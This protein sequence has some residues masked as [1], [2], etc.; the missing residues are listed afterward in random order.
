MATNTKRKEKLL[1]LTKIFAIIKK[2]FF[3]L[4]RD[5]I[6]IIPL[7]LMPVFMILILGFVTGNTPK[8]I[9]TAIVSY[10]NSPISQNIIQAI[11]GNQYF[12]VGKLVGE[13]GQ[14][15]QLLD[16]GEVEVIVEIPPNFGEDIANSVQT[17]IIVI[18]DESD[19]SIAMTARQQLQMIVQGIASQLARNKLEAYQQSVSS[20]AN[21][22]NTYVS[23]SQNV[24]T[25]INPKLQE[26]QAQLMASQNIL[27]QQRAGLFL[28]S[29]S[30]TSLPLNYNYSSPQI[31][32]GQTGPDFVLSPTT[33]AQLAQ[34]NM[35]DYLLSINSKATNDINSI[36]SSALSIGKNSVLQQTSY[37]NIAQALSNIKLFYQSNS[38]QTLQPIIYTEK[39][40]Y[41][42]GKTPFDFLI[43]AL[44]AMTIF[45]S[46][47]MG[48]GRAVAGEKKEGSLTRVI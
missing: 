10:D 12:S 28:S 41:G 47:V 32:H 29:S 15:R 14:A 16:K 8:H 39:A 31:M 7:L 48:M 38:K 24:Y 3:V 40:A 42:T 45:Q 9:Q 44:I 17:N 35:I 4:T 20:S 25:T 19:S 5:R 27:Q 11:S 37:S 30:S 23:G 13:E 18:V 33:Q 34:L 22:I 26:V 6:R 2:N 36:S 21:Q 46:A 43:P 1:D